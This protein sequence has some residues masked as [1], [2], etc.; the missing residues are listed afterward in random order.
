MKCMANR[1][2]LNSHVDSELLSRV[3]SSTH[4]IGARVELKAKKSTTIK[5]KKEEK[6]IDPN[7]TKTHGERPVGRSKRPQTLPFTL[8]ARVVRQTNHLEMR[9][10]EAR[11]YIVASQDQ[12]HT[13]S[14][15]HHMFWLQ[16]FRSMV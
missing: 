16:P 15:R 6:K 3:P 14:K 10:G 8:H 2:Q 11:E 4:E 9:Y 12:P 13:Y 7:K 5:K 1:H